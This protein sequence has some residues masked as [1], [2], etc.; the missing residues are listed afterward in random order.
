MNKPQMTPRLPIFVFGT[1]LPDCGN[2]RVWRGLAEA[3]H[4]GLA[5]IQN[6]RLVSNGSFPYCLPS[7]GDVTTGA[8][9]Y[10]FD[11]CYDQALTKMDRL[12]GVPRHYNRKSIVVATPEGLVNAWYYIPEDWR[13]YSDLQPVFNNSW[14]QRRRLLPAGNDMWA[15]EADFR[16]SQATERTEVESW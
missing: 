2:D 14:V 10:P 1:L 7:P 5:T 4:S 15:D 6:H 9:I 13:A 3:Q 12:E 16:E 11:D 8:L